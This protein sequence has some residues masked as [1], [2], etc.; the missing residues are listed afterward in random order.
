MTVSG[1]NDG[2]HIVAE[3][4]ESGRILITVINRH[5]RTSTC[6]LS[7]A[8]LLILSGAMRR[9]GELAYEEKTQ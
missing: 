5:G 4:D 6:Q 8:N 2:E 1:E 9:L 3:A 7:P